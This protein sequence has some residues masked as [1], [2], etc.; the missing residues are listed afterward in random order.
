MKKAFMPES[1]SSTDRVWVGR[2]GRAHGL[3]GEVFLVPD[4]DNPERFSEGAHFSTDEEPARR[5]ELLSIR[6]H[7]GRLLARFSGIEDRTAA[8]SLQGVLLTIAPGE[9]RGLADDEYWPD[10]LVGLEVHDPSGELLGTV[11][12]TDVE[13]A[14]DRL[15]VKTLEGRRAA[16]PFVRD[17]VPEVRVADGFLVVNPIEGL[18]NPSP[19]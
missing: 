3:R 6:R 8:E 14:Q 7:Q 1:S 4:T 5:L 18:L 17:L 11:E 19:D 13:G 9:R 12:A 2:L 15:I 10:E 16:I